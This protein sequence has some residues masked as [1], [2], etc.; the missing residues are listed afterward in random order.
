MAGAGASS[1]ET[2]V[3]A[4]GSGFT[5]ATQP[6]SQTVC[7]GSTATFSASTTGGSGLT[8]QWQ[9]SID[10]GTT[11]SNLAGANATSYTT[12]PL[13]ASA[14]GTEYQMV[15]SNTCGSTAT[16]TAATLTVN[17]FPVVWQQPASQTIVSNW[18]AVF[19]VQASAAL[20]YQWQQ[21]GTNLVNG[22]NISG[23]TN[24]VLTLA[25]V[26]LAYSGYTYTCIVGNTCNTTTSTPPATLT[27]NSSV[28]SNLLLQFGFE[29]T[30]TTTTDSVSGVSLNLVDSFGSPVDLHG[31]PGSGVLGQGQ[32]LSLLGGAQGGTGP[33][34]FTTNN[35]QAN[36]GTISSFTVTMWI[37][38]NTAN[39]NGSG[40]FSRY[41]TIGTNGI[42]DSSYNTAN[43][44]GL[45]N[46]ANYYP[47]GLTSLTTYIN[48]NQPPTTTWGAYPLTANQW[49]FLAV[50]YDGANIKLYGGAQ[51]VAATLASSGTNF[52]Q[53]PVNGVGPFNLFLGNRLAQDRAFSGLMD[54]VRFYRGAA[55]ASVVEAIRQAAVNV[56][57]SIATNPVSQSVCEGSTATFSVAT[58]GGSGLTYQWQESYDG[59]QSW[60]PISGATGTN[61]TTGTLSTS[62]NGEEYDVVVSSAFASLP[63]SPA[64]L[65][66]NAIPT[67]VVQ[68][69]S[70]TIASNWTAIFEAQVTGS[71]LY[72]QWQQNGTNLVDGANV[73]GSTNTVLT[74]AGVPLAFSGSTFACVVGSACG[75]IS[76]PP[77][78]LTVSA[79]PATNMFV[80]FQFKDS[81]TT[82]TDSVAGVTLSL[83]DANGNPTDLHGGP[84]SGVAGLGQALNLNQPGSV[85]G[86]LG[87][88]A[89]V[90]GNSQ[91]NFG[92]LDTFTM[93]MWLNPSS[94]LNLGS[95]SRFLVLGTDGTS[96]GTVTNTLELL[97]NSSR[98]GGTVT[99]V[100]EVVNTLQDNVFTFGAVPIPTNQW[101]FLAASYDGQ[102]LRFYGCSQYGPVS[103]QC[104]QSFQAGNVSIGSAFSL[105]LGNR[106]TQDR[107]FDGLMD[108][109]RVYPGA[110]VSAADLE[111]IRLAA[112]PTPPPPVA[113]FT[114]LPGSGVRPL[115]VTFADLSS[116]VITNL[117]WSFGDGTTTNTPASNMLTHVY[118]VASNA[119]TAIL[120]ASGPGGASMATNSITVTMPNPAQITSLAAGAGSLTIQGANGPAS[121]SQTY[122]YELLTSTNLAFAR[123]NWTVVATNAFNPD[124]SFSNTIPLA[125]GDPQRFYLLQLP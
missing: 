88:L 35:S 63:S 82:T 104:Q 10:A 121:A 43:A 107:C 23:S 64:T 58:S 13:L 116:G 71:A 106:A 55:P 51:A 100:E 57:F 9:S 119:Y 41:F 93:T 6:I 19:T 67:I 96:D 31:A 92:T 40:I 11:W 32:S 79:N 21:N 83:V 87:P 112:S 122:Y 29:D 78:I 124:G 14:N 69:S 110:V 4:V 123:S 61:Y 62:D 114:A 28:S 103:L 47:G 38:P 108:D 18:T 17:A 60:N 45:I 44:I 91:V 113:S 117:L 25:N 73:S 118:L 101:T 22:A 95:F 98:L 72:Y 7:Q 80:Q 27:V 68:P 5:W 36:F 94:P 50:T 15:V 86:G 102:T 37:N 97:S 1:G 120:T 109:V 77:A 125:P 16:T 111:S 65:T 52:L 85:Q 75:P 53:A 105:F 66:V 99:S 74:L 54:D 8:Y 39:L 20:T 70:Q 42:G 33:M 46:D 2:S 26:P 12:A 24:P 56:P 90:T 84:G 3:I 89:S 76:S 59:G 115:N 48:A 30:G 34:A 81:G 49:T